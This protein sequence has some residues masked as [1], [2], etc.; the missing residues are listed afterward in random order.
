LYAALVTMSALLAGGPAAAQ[1]P[2]SQEDGITTQD[3]VVAD[4]Q[5]VQGSLCVGFDCI[6]N[7]SF[8]FDTIRL[9]E[10]NLR[11]M[12]EDTSTSAGFPTRDWQIII[13][14]SASGGA[15]YFGIEDVT[16]AARRLTIAEGGNV[17]IG[18]D[19]PSEKL[20]VD[21]NVLV[22]GNLIETSDVN[23][24]ENFAPVDGQEILSRVD[25]IPITT[26][27]YKSDDPAIRHI[28]PMAQDFYAAFKLGQDERH[29][30]PLD[31]NGV[32]LA[33]IQELHQLVQEKDVEI[34]QLQQQNAELEARLAALEK[35]VEG[36]GQE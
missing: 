11:I 26:W 19:A 15:S 5:I 14:D 13:N 34:R 32:A 9:K 21:G 22:N 4:D 35:L 18:V 10:N 12:F 36:I 23:S 27:N 31:A 29:I 1:G 7:E 6:N 8:G 20:Q 24:K 17:G 16:A 2:V 3:A 30:A 33:A 28:G 25:Q